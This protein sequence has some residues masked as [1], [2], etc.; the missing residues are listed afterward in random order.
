[1]ERQGFSSWG[2]EGLPGK[3][4]APQL[5]LEA[6]YQVEGGQTPLHHLKLDPVSDLDGLGGGTGTMVG[7]RVTSVSHVYKI[8]KDLAIPE[9]FD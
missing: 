1:M 4:A 2:R 6:G 5:A 8:C 7:R 3:L 9:S